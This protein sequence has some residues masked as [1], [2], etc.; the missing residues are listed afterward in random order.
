MGLVYQRFEQCGI[1]I[2]MFLG[3]R[4]LEETKEQ[5]NVYILVLPMQNRTLGDVCFERFYGMTKNISNY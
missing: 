5:Y 2:S 1:N 4:G 3:V